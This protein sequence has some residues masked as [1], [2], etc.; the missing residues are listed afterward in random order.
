MATQAA[1]EEKIEGLLVSPVANAACPCMH[2]HPTREGF[3][4]GRQRAES[5]FVRRSRQGIQ[6]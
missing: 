6:S 5:L 3:N 2:A 4:G 1:G